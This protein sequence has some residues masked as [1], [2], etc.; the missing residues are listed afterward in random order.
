MR[1]KLR[2]AIPD[3]LR[4][5][6]SGLILVRHEALNAVVPLL[7]HYPEHSAYDNRVLGGPQVEGAELPPLAVDALGDAWDGAAAIADALRAA[8]GLLGIDAGTW[9]AQLETLHGRHQA[10]IV[11]RGAWSAAGAVAR[12]PDVVACV[13]RDAACRVSDLVAAASFLGDG[14]R[15]AAGAALRAGGFA[16]AL[17]RLAGDPAADATTLAFLGRAVHDM[18]HWAALAA[19]LDTPN[20]VPSMFALLDAPRAALALGVADFVHHLRRATPFERDEIA[21]A[22]DLGGCGPQDAGDCFERAVLAALLEVGPLEAAF[23]VSSDP[24][25]RRSD[26]N[27]ASGGDDH[28]LALDAPAPWLEPVWDPSTRRPLL[29]SRRPTDCGDAS[30]EGFARHL[31]RSHRERNATTGEHAARLLSQVA[32]ICRAADAEP[33]GA[34]TPEHVAPL[35]G[36]SRLAVDDFDAA[37]VDVRELWSGRR[38]AKSWSNDDLQRALEAGT[39][40]FAGGNVNLSVVADETCAPAA[41]YVYAEDGLHGEAETFCG[42]GVNGAPGRARAAAQVLAKHEA[43]REGAGVPGAPSSSTGRATPTSSSPGR[44]GGSGL[45][46]RRPPRVAYGAPDVAPADA[47]FLE[48]ECPDAF[49]ADCV[50]V[51]ATRVLLSDVLP[52]RGGEARLKYW[53]DLGERFLYELSVVADPPPAEAARATPA[54]VGGA[55]FCPPENMGLP[56]YCRVSRIIARG[57]ARVEFSTAG[58][59]GFWENTFAFVAL[60]ANGSLACAAPGPNREDNWSPADAQA[61]LD[62]VARSNVKSLAGR[63]DVA[64]DAD[65]AFGAA[66][67]PLGSREG[68]RMADLEK[69]AQMTNFADKD[70]AAA[71]ERNAIYDRQIRLWGK[72]A[73]KKIGGTK[74]LFLGFASVN[75]ELCKNLVLAGFSATIA[76]D[77]VVAPAALACN[78]FLGAGDAGRNVAEASA[79]AAAELNPFAAV[80][81]D[82]RGLAAAST[83]AGAAAL[84]AGHGVVV[85]EARSGGGMDDCAARVDAACRDAG[86]VF[87]AVRCGGDGAVAFLDLGPEHSYV[88][89]TGSGEKLKVSEPATAR[90]CSYDDM[91]SVAWADVTP[92]R[93]KQPPLQFLFDRLDAL[94]WASKH[95]EGDAKKRKTG[96]GSAFAAFA[97]RALA[98]RGLAGAASEGDLARAFVAAAAPIAPVAAVVGGILGQEVVAVSGKARRRTTFV[99][100]AA[101]GAGTAP[102]RR[103]SRPR[104]PAAPPSAEDAI[105]L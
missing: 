93:G 8:L 101:T 105:E 52:G 34:A 55:R 24:R 11:S 1:Y 69:V 82:G 46:P 18:S 22:G 97:A 3:L 27:L 103:P 35:V 48:A 17:A 4:L 15:A 12:G 28:A 14:A 33:R 36:A 84:V 31:L 91:R 88:V 47:L 73:Q 39:I 43:D 70:E 6:S 85:V 99:F 58:P 53:Y 41:T 83:A 38:V 32:Q 25:E 89:E 76:D 61:R 104:S 50:V 45:E 98:D 10:D 5:A 68:P 75:V 80:G 7:S 23:R 86:A 62:A 13:R 77:G 49:F 96:D 92:P 94:F 51:D 63:C 57:P 67:P 29:G 9:E 54:V 90:Y 20:F 71:A 95:G 66:A 64:I 79:A 100:D 59:G 30:V 19:A 74:V 56:T 2:L 16:D 72:D 21:R 60:S 102:A 26:R 81:H 37:G 44:R 65:G 87:L 78:F 42:S 40:P